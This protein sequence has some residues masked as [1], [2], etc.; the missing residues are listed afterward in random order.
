MLFR[1]LVLLVVSD[2]SAEEALQ[3]QAAS[4]LLS[5][6]TGDNVLSS[7]SDVVQ[8]S[9]VVQAVLAA[10]PGREIVIC[11]AG[12]SGGHGSVLWQRSRTRFVETI[13][14]TAG[15]ALLRGTMGEASGNTTRAGRTE[16][17]V[18]PQA[19]AV[20][21]L[22]GCTG[23]VGVVIW[24]GMRLAWIR[25]ERKQDLM[26]ALRRLGD[27]LIAQEAADQQTEVLGLKPRNWVGTA[28]KDGLQA[29][30]GVPAAQSAQAPSL[31]VVPR[32]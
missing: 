5:S 9:A 27:R 8:D 11:L 28:A 21:C 2:A 18:A 6:G 10:N 7:G 32:G 1:S 25:D 31:P 14:G 29:A 17:D 23:P 3:Q 4:P 22:A 30:F 12:C 20:I 13:D 26:A 19:E 15:L 24:R 16:P